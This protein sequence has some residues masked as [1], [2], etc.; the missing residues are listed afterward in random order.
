MLSTGGSA[1]PAAAN[2]GSVR[3]KVSAGTYQ[4]V[5]AVAAD[6]LTFTGKDTRYR[7]FAN[8]RRC[9]RRG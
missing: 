5:S 4:I 7:A 1:A 3:F 2:R 9:C 6:E 8:V